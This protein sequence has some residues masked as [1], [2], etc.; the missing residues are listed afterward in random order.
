MECVHNA[1]R[2]AKIGDSDIFEVRGRVLGTRDLGLGPG[3]EFPDADVSQE[4]VSAH[5]RDLTPKDLFL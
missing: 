2:R 1:E 5:A 3:V 4:P